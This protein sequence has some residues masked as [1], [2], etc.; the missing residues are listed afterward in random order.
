MSQ[1]LAYLRINLR[2]P[3]CST[4]IRKSVAVIIYRAEGFFVDDW[5]GVVGG[6][7]CLI[8]F[9]RSLVDALGLMVDVTELRCYARFA[10]LE[11]V[12]VA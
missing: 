12:L 9:T 7:L 2:N 11:L 8:G 4:A 6:R 5:P 3:L 10:S 1:E